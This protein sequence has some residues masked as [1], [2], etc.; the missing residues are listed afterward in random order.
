MPS[1]ILDNSHSRNR[2]I[3]F[4]RQ[5][6]ERVA[7]KDSPSC[8]VAW[9]A[10]TGD[11]KPV[12]HRGLADFLEHIS[13]NPHEVTTID[14]IPKLHDDDTAVAEWIDAHIAKLDALIVRGITQRRDAKT[15]IGR[16]L[17]E[18][19]QILGHGKF[20]PHVSEVL[21]SMISLRT[22]QRFMKFAREEDAKSK[23]DNLTFLNSASDDGAKDIKT[24]TERA[25]AEVNSRLGKQKLQKMGAIYKL[26]LPLCSADRKAVDELRESPA[27][28]EA[29][30]SIILELRRLCTEHGIETGMNEE[31]EHESNSADT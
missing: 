20:E 31:E 30:Q 4:G 3:F 7:A 21:G 29:E 22:A 23:N 16:A 1:L 10:R 17:N 24:T 18:Q 19:K 8:A 15:E 26:P 12:R 6:W 14:D 27:W 5:C 9:R 28:P 13:R 11:Q 25:R 2:M